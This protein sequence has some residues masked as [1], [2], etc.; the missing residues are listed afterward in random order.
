AD[1]HEAH[2]AG[3]P[4]VDGHRRA[5]P[6]TVGREDRAQPVLVVVD[7]VAHDALQVVV[8]RAGLRQAR[9]PR[10]GALRSLTAPAASPTTGTP[11]AA[12][13][14]LRLLAPPVDELL[15]HLRQETARRVR[16]RVAP[17]G[18]QHRAREVELLAG[19]GD[20]H[21]RQTPLLRQLIRV[22][23]GPQ[24]RE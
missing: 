20:A 10:G 4:E 12:P 18:A 14:L 15:R 5:G 2:L 16:H 11:G 13:G 6:G 21:V 3:G 24:V 1:E 7:P 22:A 9:L 19:T 8:L 23:Q 17:R